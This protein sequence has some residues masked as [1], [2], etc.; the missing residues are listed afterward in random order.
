MVL[1]SLSRWLPML[2]GREHAARV[3]HEIIGQRIRAFAPSRFAAHLVPQRAFELGKCN[4][5]FERAIELGQMQHRGPWK[6]DAVE[7]AATNAKR[8]RWEPHEPKRLI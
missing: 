7:L 1:S 4:V 8:R 5:A 2:P 3:S 6:G